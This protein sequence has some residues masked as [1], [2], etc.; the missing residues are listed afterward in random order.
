MECSLKFLIVDDSA[1]SRRM[2]RSCVE[3]L[4]HT[5]VEATDGAAGLERYV[6]EKPDFV[7]LDLLMPGLSGFEVLTL[8]R[9]IDGRAQV[10][11]CT[12][13]VQSSTRELIKQ[14]GASAII[15][16]PVSIEQISSTLNSVLSGETISVSADFTVLS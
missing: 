4:G 6:V 8:L 9:A 13:D 12:A 2:I 1:L 15:N 10:I 5:A 14:S 16:K 11:V 7:F 3:Q